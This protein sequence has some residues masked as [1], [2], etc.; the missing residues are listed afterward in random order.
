[1]IVIRTGHPVLSRRTVLQAAGASFALPLLEAMWPGRRG[2]AQ[3][4]G[5]IPKRF[6]VFFT[7]NGTI[8]PGWVPS[9]GET[10]FTLS[11]ILAPLSAFQR[12][13]VVVSGLFQEGAGGDGHQTGIG[14]MLTG[15]SLN[16][17]PFQ[18]ACRQ[19][20]TPLQPV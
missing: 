20:L 1:M 6:V 18:G 14:G 4:A 15:Q 8:F 10:A 19:G 9:G 3:A 2:R 5:V 7:P 17:G 16:P 12:D 11:P 13:L